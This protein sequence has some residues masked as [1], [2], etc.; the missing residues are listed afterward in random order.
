MRRRIFFFALAVLLPA[1]CVGEDP[2]LVV[3]GTG[4]GIDGGDAA[5]LGTAGDA[6]TDARAEV[7][8]DASADARSCQ[9]PAECGSGGDCADAD[10]ID[11]RCWL[12]PRA[13]DAGCGTKNR[14]DGAGRC[15]ECL[16]DAQCP[17]AAGE[18]RRAK[19]NAGTCGFENLPAATLC[20][21][22]RDQCDGNGN[23]VD[24]VNSGG[25]DECCVCS[26]KTCV[27][28]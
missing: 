23:C 27:P 8:L 10:C 1:A 20:N 14:C 19:C 25:C 9:G 11:G 13:A 28:A 3:A 26:N 2:V 22:L 17:Q 18:C 7:S 21:G 16:T 24:C 5:P 4:A 12:V 15:V 6:E